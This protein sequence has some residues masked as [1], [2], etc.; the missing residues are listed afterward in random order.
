MRFVLRAAFSALMSCWS[1][2]ARQSTAQSQPICHQRRS[3]RSKRMSPCCTIPTGRSPTSLMDRSVKRRCS[4]RRSAT[5]P[6]ACRRRQPFSPQVGRIDSFAT[7][8]QRPMAWLLFVLNFTISGCLRRSRTDQRIESF[9]AL[10]YSANSSIAAPSS[11][12]LDDL[13]NV[14]DAVVAAAHRLVE[15][16][17]GS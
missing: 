15:T 6:R 8:L 3:G 11:G 7:R 9:A 10:C 4:T 1:S 2:E 5:T 14:S 13:H 12:R 16:S 17:S